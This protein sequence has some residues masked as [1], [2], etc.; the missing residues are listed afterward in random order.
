[1]KY[2][3][4]KSGHK[5]QRCMLLA[6]DGSFQYIGLHAR[7]LLHKP[8]PYLKDATRCEQLSA[9]L[10]STAIPERGRRLLPAVENT[11]V[12]MIWKDINY[13]S[14]ICGTGMQRGG[15]IEGLRSE[16]EGIEAGASKPKA[17]CRLPGAWSL[18]PRAALP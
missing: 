12:H 14:F 17:A 16:A 11:S 6:L 10:H 2:L 7:P 1:M 9:T 4:D 8:K 15:C 18:E 13:V 3:L 5:A